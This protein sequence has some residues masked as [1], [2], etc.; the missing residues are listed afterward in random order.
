M[1]LGDGSNLDDNIVDSKAKKVK[2]PYSQ[3]KLELNSKN[4]ELKWCKIF[5]SVF[6]SFFFALK[7]RFQVVKF[8]VCQIK[9]R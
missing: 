2:R 4:V 9:L 6:L 7:V 5:S 8:E 3:S 1:M